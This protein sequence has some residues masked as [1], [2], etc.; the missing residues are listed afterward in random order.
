MSRVISLTN[1]RWGAGKSGWV[2]IVVAAAAL[3]GGCSS[4]FVPAPSQ[5]RQV[6]S[7]QMQTGSARRDTVSAPSRSARQAQNGRGWGPYSGARGQ[8]APPADEHFVFR[9]D[10]NAGTT[11]AETRVQSAERSIR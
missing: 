10:Q 3:A 8:K 2:G 1:L 5:A 4:D 9:G 7:D 6:G 11:Y